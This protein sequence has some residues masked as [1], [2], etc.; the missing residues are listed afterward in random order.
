MLMQSSDSNNPSRATKMSNPSRNDIAA[1]I[2]KA[3]NAILKR[4]NSTPLS[5]RQI[6]SLKDS[7]ADGPWCVSHTSLPTPPREQHD[8]ISILM[9]AIARLDQGAKT[10]AT[11]SAQ[12]IEAEWL[13]YCEDSGASQAASNQAKY[14]W[15]SSHTEHQPTIF[16]IQGGGFVSAPRSWLGRFFSLTS[17]AG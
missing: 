15:I 10:C 6:A 14:D 16:Y 17:H 13:V 11:P 12:V 1:T 7:S 3:R 8:T 9:K 2:A 4:A 5:I